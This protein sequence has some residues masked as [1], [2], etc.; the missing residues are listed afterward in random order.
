MKSFL[1]AILLILLGILIAGLIGLTTAP[2]RGEPVILLPP[3]TPLPIVVHVSGMVANPGLVTLP[4]GSRAQEALEAAGGPLPEADLSRVNLA[5][6]LVDGTQL[7]IPARAA[8]SQSSNET[9]SSLVPPTAPLNINTAT[10]DE[11]ATL[12]G[13]GPTTAQRIVEYRTQFGPFT[14]LADL[15][16]V[17]GLGPATIEQI[18]DLITIGP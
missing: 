15:T 9:A 10:A 16:Q 13:I 12:P 4:S 11:L 1:T 5:A 14:T 17:F 18:K 6:P 8:S 3:P 2:P 7:N